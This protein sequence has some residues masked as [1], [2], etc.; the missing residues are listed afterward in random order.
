MKEIGASV[1]QAIKDSV[2]GK[3]TS[4]P[5]VGTLANGGVSLAPFHDSMRRSPTSSGP[6]WTS[7]RTISSPAT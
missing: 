7:S 6:S 2:D 4:D 1:E 5:Y 3:F